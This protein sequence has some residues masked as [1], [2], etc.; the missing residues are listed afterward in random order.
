MVFNRIIPGGV[1]PIKRSCGKRGRSGTAGRAVTGIVRSARTRSTTRPCWNG[2][3]AL[4][5]E[6]DGNKRPPAVA[7]AGV[8]GVVG[9]SAKLAVT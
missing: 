8:V 1:S 3:G 6:P 5:L 7:R 4:G 9:W 2:I